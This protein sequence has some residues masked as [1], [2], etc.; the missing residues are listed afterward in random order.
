[1]PKTEKETTGDVTI[2]VT[3]P[4]E[5]VPKAAQALVELV[6]KGYCSLLAADDFQESYVAVHMK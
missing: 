2:V 3:G 1:M 5:G 6:N 4:K